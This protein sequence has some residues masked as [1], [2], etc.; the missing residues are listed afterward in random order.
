MSADIYPSRGYAVSETQ[1]AF[2]A[3]ILSERPVGKL[4]ELLLLRAR[5]YELWPARPNGN[6]SRSPQ[7]VRPENDLIRKAARDVYNQSS[8]KPN[9]T[10]AERLIRETLKAHRPAMK[11]TRT[12]IRQVLEEDEFGQ[13]RKP[14]GNSRPRKS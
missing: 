1:L 4:R 8:S 6:P 13:Q 12:A 2:Y 10:K 9:I 14:A 3:G 5:V 11:A 7:P